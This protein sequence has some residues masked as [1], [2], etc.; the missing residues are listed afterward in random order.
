ME[1]IIVPSTP[2][3]FAVTEEIRSDI[4]EVLPKMARRYSRPGGIALFIQEAISEK[5]ERVRG[6]A[7]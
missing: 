6:G 1:Q 5:V 3:Q 4:A 2:K 7:D